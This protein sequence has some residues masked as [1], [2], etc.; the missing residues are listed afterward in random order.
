MKIKVYETPELTS[1]MT[2]TPR[3]KQC[4]VT[5][6]RRGF[7]DSKRNVVICERQRDNGKTGKIFNTDFFESIIDLLIYK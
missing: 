5:G 7:Y 6:L 3:L 4:H 1:Q 2:Q